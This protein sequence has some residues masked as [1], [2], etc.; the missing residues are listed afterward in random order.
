MSKNKLSSAVTSIIALINKEFKAVRVGQYVTA[1]EDAGEFIFNSEACDISNATLQEIAKK[2]KIQVNK[3]ATK[4]ELI[5]A[6]V[7]G[8]AALNLPQQNEKPDSLIVKEIVQAGLEKDLEDEDMIVQI[9]EAGIKY[10]N[11]VKL[12]QNAVIELGA[13][14]SNK[15]RKEKA[16]KILKDEEF[17]PTT[18][19]EVSAMAERLA[20][21]IPDT[22]LSKAIGVIKGYCKEN[23]IEYP[24]PEKGKGVVGGFKGKFIAFI[25]NDPDASD[26]AIKK[27]VKDNGKEDRA[28]ERLLRTLAFAKKYHEAKVKKDS[29]AKTEGKKS[30]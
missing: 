26:E 16:Y 22:E 29:G 27:F 10:K 14:I 6:L 28:A 11:A 24:K 5:A 18:F 19:E 25:M 15:D 30:K 12:F 2:N 23:E 20:E 4:D 13:R 3:G 9:I 1:A 17:A 21:E 7:P 8:I